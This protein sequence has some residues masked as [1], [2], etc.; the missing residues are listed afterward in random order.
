MLASRLPQYQT[1][2]PWLLKYQN[3]YIIIRLLK[4]QNLYWFNHMYISA[5]GLGVFFRYLRS[6]QKLKFL[7][8]KKRNKPGPNLN[9]P[10]SKFFDWFSQLYFQTKHLLL[11]SRYMRVCDSTGHT[12]SPPQG[13]RVC[14]E[15]NLVTSIG[16]LSKSDGR[17]GC[18][19]RCSAY[20]NFPPWTDWF[21]TT[22][23]KQRCYRKSTPSTNGH[24][25]PLSDPVRIIRTVQ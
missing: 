4:Y 24:A 12:L 6:S 10:N 18:C 5:V 23:P 25:E 11:V 19:W 21:I 1:P 14:W 7:L 15:P 2:Y 9:G 20:I 8:F 16:S 22:Y 13:R 17:W 3:P